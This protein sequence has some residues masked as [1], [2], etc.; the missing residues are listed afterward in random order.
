M[1]SHLRSA[2]K[3]VV[4]RI[5]GILI[6]AIIT[7]AFTRNWIQTGLVTFIHHAVFLIVFYLHERFWLRFPIKRYLLQSIVKVLTYETFLGNVILGTITYLVTGNVK[8]MTMITL[9]YIGIKHIVYVINEFVWRK[10]N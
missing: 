3:S 5:T 7:Y 10:R 6:L 4:W 8:Q 1:E 2:T 9:T